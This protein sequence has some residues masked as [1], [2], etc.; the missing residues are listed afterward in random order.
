MTRADQNTPFVV[1]YVD[2][3]FGGLR[4]TVLTIAGDPTNAGATPTITL[5]ATGVSLALVGTVTL[6]GST[7][8]TGSSSPLTTKGDLFTYSTVAARLAVGSNGQLLVADSAAA[9]GNKW[10]AAFGSV[11][12][13]GTVSLNGPTGGIEVNHAGTGDVEVTNDFGTVTLGGG[14]AD[15]T[16][17]VLTLAGLTGL[18]T[19]AASNINL[20]PAAAGTIHVGSAVTNLLKLYGGTGVAQHSSTAQTAGFTVV[21]AS[22]VVAPESTFTGGTGTKAYTIGDVVRALKLIGLMAAS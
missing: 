10:A 21:G 4:K 15:A 9:T 6:N 17:A 22:A 19:L 18:A 3:A 16:P 13:G 20:T 2:L 12:L 11:T 8:A 7:I 14:T 5:G 1:E